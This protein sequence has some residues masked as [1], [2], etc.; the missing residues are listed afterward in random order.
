M[1]HSLYPQKVKLD[2]VE[3]KYHHDNGDEYMS[4]SRLY[5]YLSPKFDANAIA[6]HV[7]RAKDVSKAS[8]LKEWQG[9]TDAGTLFD[10][11]IKTYTETGKV[12]AEHEHLKT[13][14]IH[15]SEKYKVYNSV[16]SDLVVFN[17]KYRVAGEIDRLCLTSNRKDCTFIIS[18][19]KFMKGISMEHK[20]QRW[21]NS[22]FDHHV[23][24]KYTRISWQLSYYAHLFYL[25][26]GRKCDRLFIDLI[27]P[28][29]SGKGYVN[30]VIPVYNA[31]AEIMQFLE[32]FKDRILMDLEPK[33]EVTIETENEF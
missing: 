5:G 7:A 20:G 14:I 24:S 26:T 32:H 19:F 9:A 13:L 18:D 17:E 10:V 15:V 22:P 11:A 30:E 31:Q 16:Y 2:K 1:I 8:I 6:G 25:L 33:S 28:A 29:A 3:H 12:A 4:F 21:L 27:R 23:N